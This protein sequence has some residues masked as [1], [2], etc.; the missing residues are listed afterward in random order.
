MR[1]TRELEKLQEQAD[2][3]N[4]QKQR[5]HDFDNTIVKQVEQ[6]EILKKEI[7]GP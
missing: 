6:I 1:Q 3:I 2:I 4:E 5:L 7:K